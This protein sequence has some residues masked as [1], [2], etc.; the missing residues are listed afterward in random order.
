MGSCDSEWAKTITAVHDVV[1][2]DSSWRLYL[3]NPGVECPIPPDRIAAT[4]VTGV[5]RGAMRST[6]VVPRIDGDR[7]G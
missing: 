4:D 2:P 5:A 3:E 6:G 7:R 1:A